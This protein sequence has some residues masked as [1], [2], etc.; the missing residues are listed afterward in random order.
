MRR[1][2]VFEPSLSLLF[3]IFYFSRPKFD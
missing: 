2:L 1:R 3:L